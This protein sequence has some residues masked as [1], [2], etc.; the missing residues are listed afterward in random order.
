MYTSEV[1]QPGS[2]TPKSLPSGLRGL[3]IKPESSPQYCSEFRELKYSCHCVPD[4]KAETELM[5][6]M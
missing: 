3:E 1:M 5:V 2:L 4:T 6:D